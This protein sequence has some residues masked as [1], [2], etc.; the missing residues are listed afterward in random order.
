MIFYARRLI[1][2][3]FFLKTMWSSKIFLTPPLRPLVDPDLLL[4]EEQILPWGSTYWLLKETK[5]W[6]KE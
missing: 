5:N 4:V 1:Q 6:S 3:P 2:P